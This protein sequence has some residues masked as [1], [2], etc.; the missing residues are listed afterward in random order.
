MQTAEATTA[1]SHQGLA[2]LSLSQALAQP[3]SCAF[4]L[5]GYLCTSPSPTTPSNPFTALVLSTR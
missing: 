3:S 2:G 4:P 1:R 5:L